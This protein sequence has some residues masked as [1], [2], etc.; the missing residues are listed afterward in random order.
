MNAAVCQVMRETFLLRS[1]A[2]RRKLSDPAHGTQRL[3]PRRSRRVRC[4]AWLGR[5]MLMATESLTIKVNNQHGR[6]ESDAATNKE[7][8]PKRRPLPVVLPR[9]QVEHVGLKQQN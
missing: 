6:K 9:L 4:S 1:S 2:E 7:A 5:C 8:P 3:Q